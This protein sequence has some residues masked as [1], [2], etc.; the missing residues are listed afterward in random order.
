M[1]K[2]NTR[3]KE[4]N[5]QFKRALEKNGSPAPIFDTDDDRSYFL[6]TLKIH[7]H[8]V[9]HGA[10]HGAD[11]YIYMS[12]IEIKI[13]NELSKNETLSKTEILNVLNFAKHTKTT[14]TA[15]NKLLEQNLIQYTLPNK[16]QSKKQRYQI[17]NKG[18]SLLTLTLKEQHK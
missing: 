17:T 18:I 9:T 3:I 16:P 4:S 5:S 15:F 10:D 11:S 14:K 7:P 6:T 13:L 1:N 8:F 12:S 2:V